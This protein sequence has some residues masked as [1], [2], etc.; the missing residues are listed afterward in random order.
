M[1]LSAR[2]RSWVEVVTLCAVGLLLAVC[3]S[4]RRTVAAATKKV[5]DKA[6]ADSGR[7]IA[8]MPAGCTSLGICT[9]TAV[10]SSYSAT[11]PTNIS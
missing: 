2:N 3:F 8:E 5:R 6:C 7:H 1:A 4:S 11:L 10:N 9:S